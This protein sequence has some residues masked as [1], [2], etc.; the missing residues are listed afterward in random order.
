MRCSARSLPCA[1]NRHPVKTA[2]MS[3][4]SSAEVLASHNASLDSEEIP[5]IN[6]DGAADLRLFAEGPPVGGVRSTAARTGTA[7]T[8]RVASPSRSPDISTSKFPVLRQL[9]GAAG[10]RDDRQ[11]D[12]A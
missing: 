7:R 11:G 12:G 6:V 5:T 3:Y 1:L 8:M 4:G 10:D 9:H 2:L